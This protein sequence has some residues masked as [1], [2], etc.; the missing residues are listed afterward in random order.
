MLSIVL[1]LA[2]VN[3]PILIYVIDGHPAENAFAFLYQE[4]KSNAQT[5][6]KHQSNVF[7]ANALKRKSLHGNI[8]R[9]FFLFNMEILPS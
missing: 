8:P 2:L 1:L 3:N 5:P 6:I 4:L 9:R 7:S